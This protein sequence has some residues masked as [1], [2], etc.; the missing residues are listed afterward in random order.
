MASTPMDVDN[1]SS[2]TTPTGILHVKRTLG[3]PQASRIGDNIYDYAPQKTF[4]RDDVKEGKPLPRILALDFDDPGDLIMT[5]ESDETIQLYSVKDGRKDKSLLSKK[6]GV[7]LARFT[8][9]SSS[10]LYA[11]TKQNDAIRYLA[12]HDNTFI[13]YFEGHTGPV[14]SISM[15]PGSDQFISSGRDDCVVLWDIKSKNHS[16]KLYLTDPYLT[17]YDPAGIVFAIGCPASGSI[18]LYDCKNYEQPFAAFDIL[19]AGY[20]KDAHAATSGWTTMLFSNDGK[21][22]LLG[23]KGTGHFLLDAFDGKLKA[24]LKKTEGNTSRLAPGELP[25]MGGE[26]LEV[27]ES[28]GD[29]CFTPD[30]RYVLGGGKRNITIWDTL[31]TIPENKELE[32]SGKLDEKGETSVVAFSP[33]YNFLATADSELTFWLPE[34][35]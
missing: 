31:A 11:S 3:G 25:A 10:I 1:D 4:R 35:P 20:D 17:A 19:E 15:H 23:T 30:G 13:R 8:H 26:A 22:L 33:R 21:H 27:F 12:T 9:N 32:P 18:I 6:Y 14:T 34:S 5:S 2:G 7:K 24:F 29:V 16:A 28:S